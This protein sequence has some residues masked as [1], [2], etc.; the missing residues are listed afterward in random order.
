MATIQETNRII[1]SRSKAITD[2]N[3]LDPNKTYDVT[4]DGYVE[5]KDPLKEKWYKVGEAAKES[6]ASQ[7][8][9]RTAIYSGRLIATQIHDSSRYGHHYLIRETD[10]IEW[11]ENK[12]E[13]RNPK[14][15]EEY[16]R[17]TLERVKSEAKPDYIPVDEDGVQCMP[18]H[19]AAERI[20]RSG[21]FIRNAINR[22]E[23]KTTKGFIGGHHAQFISEADLMEFVSKSEKL[24]KSMKRVKVLNDAETA[25]VDLNKGISGTDT[26]SGHRVELDA[27]EI[28][29]IAVA[30]I[31]KRLEG[32]TLYSIFSEVKH[33]IKKAYDLGV[34]DAKLSFEQDI[35]DEYRKGFEEG[36]KQAKDE[37]L[38]M[39]KGV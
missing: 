2:I 14:A 4:A 8:S 36:K 17:K 26:T 33:L 30:E 31:E 20:G 39:L 27:E 13:V 9:I 37:L 7:I 38:A 19:K 16:N 6:G 21:S 29:N 23:L 18:V 5:R 22:G 24:I 15:H 25:T 34:S 10:L 11:M 3:K 12:S 32:T 1:N 35:S 28:K